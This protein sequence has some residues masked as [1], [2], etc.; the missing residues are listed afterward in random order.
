MPTWLL[1][2]LVALG[3]G[4][5]IAGLVYFKSRASQPSAAERQVE[6][7]PAAAEADASASPAAARYAKILE[8][9][10]FRLNEERQKPQ[11]RMLVVNHS[12][13]QI[14][15]LML[16]VT[17]SS[18]D[19]KELGTASADVAGIDPLG[20]LEVTAPLK[21]SLRAYELPDWQFV[22]AQFSVSER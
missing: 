21:T 16:K 14:G 11:V 1:M 22:R 5:L 20:S 10:G 19:G 13:A 9:T 2:L 4:G 18:T 3:V 6:A 8:I 15:S 7:A 12:G 17:L